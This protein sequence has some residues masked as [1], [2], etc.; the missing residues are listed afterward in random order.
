MS[1]AKN[2]NRK[3]K[4]DYGKDWRAKLAANQI[5]DRPQWKNPNK[6]VKK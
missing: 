5:P 4:R 3:M 1:R 6:E 2:Y